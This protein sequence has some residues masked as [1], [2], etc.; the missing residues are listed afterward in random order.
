[1]PVSWC[2]THGRVNVA[3]PGPCPVGGEETHGLRGMS[4]TGTLRRTNEEFMLNGTLLARC[5]SDDPV[6]AG[7]SFVIDHGFDDGDV[8]TV[9]GSP[10][11]V[12]DLSVFCMTSIRAAVAAPAAARGMAAA[13]PPKAAAK[14]TM[15]QAS[16]KKAMK[17][18]SPKKAMKR[19]A[20]KKAMKRAAP[21]KAVKRAAPKK[22]ATRPAPAKK[23]AATKKSRSRSAR[24]GK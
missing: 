5:D 15:K 12:G 7:A 14:K 21:K 1:M 19:A 4:M 13:A 3:P 16:P 24:K 9:E 17:Q 20:P 23:K 6:S 8:V 22:A 10:G 2:E 11:K 18:A